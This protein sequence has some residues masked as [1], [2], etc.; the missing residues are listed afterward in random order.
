M[1]Y[2]FQWDFNKERINQNKHGVTFREAT[3]VFQDPMALTLFDQEHSIDED[4]WI[5]LGVTLS[6]QYLVVVHTFD[7]NVNSDVSIRMISARKATRYEIQQYEE[8]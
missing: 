5:T 1:Q 2:N 4:R 8:L 7:E 6:G 3:Q